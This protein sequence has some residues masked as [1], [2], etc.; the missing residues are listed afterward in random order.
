MDRGI[1]PPSLL[2]ILGWALLQCLQSSPFSIHLA[3]S[4]VLSSPAG[5]L[6]VSMALTSLIIQGPAAILS[7]T[8]ACHLSHT[9]AGRWHVHPG[10]YCCTYYQPFSGPRLP[11]FRFYGSQQPVPLRFTLPETQEDHCLVSDK[12][13]F[14]QVLQRFFKAAGNCKHVW[15]SVNWRCEYA[16][17]LGPRHTCTWVHAHTCC[18]TIKYSS[19][20]IQFTVLKNCHGL[21]SALSSKIIMLLA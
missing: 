15:I 7:F 19:Q 6:P 1:E 18:I 3:N 10:W 13:N 11:V 2:F 21:I 5:E 8:L 16:H 17:T 4:P 9:N 12:Y 20:H 14:A